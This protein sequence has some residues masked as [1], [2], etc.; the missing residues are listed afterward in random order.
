MAHGNERPLVKVTEVTKMKEPVGR[1]TKARQIELNEARSEALAEKE[2]SNPP[3]RKSGRL[4]AK[5]SVVVG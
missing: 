3:L 4:Q 1:P 5:S 2:I